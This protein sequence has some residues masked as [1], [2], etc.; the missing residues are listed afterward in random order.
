MQKG[1]IHIYCGDGKGK[2]TTSIGLSIRAAGNNMNVLFTQFLK[3]SK[4][5]ELNILKTI[6]N[7]DVMPFDKDFGF[8]FKMSPETKAEASQAYT[9]LLN[10]TF[11]K[12]N[13][14][15]YQLLVLD[16][17]MATVK[18]EFVDE[19]I[20]INHLENK[21]ED[22][23]VVMTGR[24]PS[25]RLIEIADYVSEIKKIKHPFDCGIPAR[26]GIEK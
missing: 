6:P 11:E 20:L 15:S 18:L 3:D 5:S 21:N 12:A 7:I 2:T 10:K 1:L 14:N 17:I 22:L 4:S 9:E 26:K 25:S 8:S 24:N 13:N 23:E 16:E 19:D